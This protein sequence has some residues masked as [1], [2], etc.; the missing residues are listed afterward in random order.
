MTRKIPA[1]M[2]SQHPDHAQKPYYHSTEFLGTADEIKE[3][4]V[5]FSELGV[6]ECMWDWEGKLVDESVIE[7]LL[8]NHYDFFKK[9][10]LGRDK[11]LT[12]RVPD[13]KTKNEFRLGRA[14]MVLLSA[15]RLAKHIGMYQKP[16]FEV[17]MPMVKSAEEMISLQHAFEEIAS[18]KHSV[19]NHTVAPD[20]IEIIPLF[21]EINIIINSDKILKNYVE[22][23]TEKFKKVP[24]YI[25]PFIARSD[26]AL[27]AGLI[28]S[29]LAT[30]VALSKYKEFERKTGIRIFP[31]IGAGSLPFRGGINPDTVNQ[32]VLE[33]AGCKT[34]LLQS[35]FRYDY[36]ADHVKQAVKFLEKKLPKGE[37]QI[38]PAS[39]IQKIKTINKIFSKYYQETIS[40]VASEISH[41]AAHLPKRRE[42]MKHFGSFKYSRKIGKK[43]LPRAI[44]FTGTLY[45]LGVP[46]E[47]IGT[48][49]GLREIKELG[50]LETLEKHYLFL[51]KDLSLAGSYLNKQ[52]LQR[53]SEV[54]PAWKQVALDIHHLEEYL[55]IP[56]CPTTPQQ[57]KHHQLSDDIYKRFISNEDIT[58]DIFDAAVLRKSIG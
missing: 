12:F 26:P 52:T 20:H 3:C 18:L 44:G 54:N 5:A 33:Y 53:L 58:E 48:G 39:D 27:S 16:L 31:I 41:F 4:F 2:A 29:V 49:R 34:V 50:L 45:S 46:P 24:E 38:I 28:P 43:S 15:A 47:L 23:Y 21:E 55:N 8:S 9:N 30:K 25:R 10:Q 56:L 57:L 51:E 40:S 17:I 42:R 7:K 11:F 32:F 14:F 22:W 19:Y 6:S 1:T 36:E 13:I 37:A 35:A